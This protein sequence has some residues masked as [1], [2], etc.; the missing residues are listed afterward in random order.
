MMAIIET[1]PPHHYNG[2]YPPGFHPW[3]EKVKDPYGDAKN[4]KNSKDV[5]HQ[6]KVKQEKID[7]TAFLAPLDRF[8]RGL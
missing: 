3:T 7:R 5:K 4:F 6:E 1:D 8:T 2:P